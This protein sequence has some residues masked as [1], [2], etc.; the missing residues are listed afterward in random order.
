TV[1]FVPGT[2]EISLSVEDLSAGCADDLTQSF[3][4]FAPPV[5]EAFGDTICPG[6]TAQLT[7][8]NL[9]PG[10]TI[11]WTPVDDI[12]GANNES[13]VL[14]NPAMTTEYMLEVEDTL[15][16]ISNS[17]LTID[18][19]QPLPFADVDSTRCPGDSLL[20][21]LPQ[22]DGFHIVEWVPSPPPLIVGEEDIESTLIITDI[23]ECFLDEYDFRVLSLSD[24]VLVTNVFSP[25]GDGTNDVFRVYSEIDFERTDLIQIVSFEV[26]NRWG[27]KV[28]DAS[29]PQAIWDGMHNGKPAP[30]DV[31]IY[32]IVVDVPKSGRSWELEG[33]V[34]LV[35]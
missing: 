32:R 7:I 17:S 30:S 18:V 27:V 19:I 15:G 14:A 24:T 29:G 25:N 33:Q 2:Y 10:S 13:V 8:L 22:G 6:D 12:I 16:C 34:T 3:T 20:I 1:F 23:L 9:E 21:D 26:Y 5:A 11:Q 35:R 31:Y 4:F 28:Y